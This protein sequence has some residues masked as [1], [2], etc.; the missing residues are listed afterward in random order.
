MRRRLALAAVTLAAVVWVAALFVAPIA[1]NSTP[2]MRRSAAVCYAAGSLICHQRT[3]R[4]FH[5][6]AVQLPVCARCTGLYTGAAIGAI[7]WMAMAGIGDRSATAALRVTRASRPRW[8]L[9]ASA[10][11]TLV[12]LATAAL[13]VRDPGN[14]TRALLAIPLGVTIGAAVA[15]V[16]ARDLR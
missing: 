11:P 1:G 16:A 15:A 12:T 13:G 7:L 5:I 8:I 10:V 2:L 3:E 4:S 6:A 14:A 9:I